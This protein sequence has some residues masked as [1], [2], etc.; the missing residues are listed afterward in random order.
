M[1]H[2]NVPHL[3][4][5]SMTYHIDLYGH[6]PHI[7]IFQNYMFL[8]GVD[9]VWVSLDPDMASLSGFKTASDYMPCDYKSYIWVSLDPSLTSPESVSSDITNH[10]GVTGPWC[11]INV[12]LN[13]AFDCVSSDSTNHGFNTACDSVSSDSTNHVGVTGS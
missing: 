1:G 11:G 8:N 13:T 10:V 2:W 7:W 6:F 12:W 5:L 3:V 4:A 9:T